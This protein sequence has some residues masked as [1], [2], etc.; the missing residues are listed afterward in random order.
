LAILD[1]E[2]STCQ[3]PPGPSVAGRATTYWKAHCDGDESKAPLVIK[4]SWQYPE[5]EEEG[6]LLREATEKEVNIIRDNVPKGLDITGATNYKPEGSM[7][8]SST[9]H[10]VR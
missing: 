9:S 6:E 3:Q 1:D 4:D 7:M 8:P 5:D 10:T 2:P